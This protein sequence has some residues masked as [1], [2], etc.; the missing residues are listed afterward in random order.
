MELQIKPGKYVIAVSGGVDSAVL[1]DVL[2]KLKKLELVVAHYDHGIRENSKDDRRFAQ[3]L[4]KKYNLKFEYANGNLGKK[5]S[6]VKARIAR[7]SFLNQVVKKYNYLAIITAHH[8][9]DVLETLIM[10]LL[11]GTGRKGLSS[12]R[13]N[14]GIV[15]PLLGYSKQQITDY[16]VANCLKWHEDSTNTNTDYFRNWVRLRVVSKLSANQRQKFLNSQ[17]KLQTVNIEVEALLDKFIKESDLLDLR[18]T[19][20]SDEAGILGKSSMLNRQSVIMLPHNLAKELIAHWLRKN[21]IADFDSVLI[22][23]I[24]ID[25]KTYA[26]GK[27]TAVKKGISV[28][29]TKVSLKLT[30]D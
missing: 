16:A 15:R 9:D 30:R 26:T 12:L 27:R 24:V 25:A 23:K 5:A 4:A 14:N 11:R 2:S 13:S 10:N 7:Y 28:L 20:G 22:E 8:Q 19:S 21:G 3:Q 18:K 6:E 29:Y 1:L 17:A